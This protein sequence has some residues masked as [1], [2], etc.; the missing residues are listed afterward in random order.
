MD[1]V[2]G[3]MREEQ[4]SQEDTGLHDLKSPQITGWSR[5]SVD[6]DRTARP[7]NARWVP[8]RSVVGNEPGGTWSKSN[9]LCHLFEPMLS[10]AIRFAI[11][12]LPK[13]L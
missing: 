6:V 12:L 3:C 11:L 7:D 4:A 2:C 1:L 13:K 5:S 8:I 9:N 10:S